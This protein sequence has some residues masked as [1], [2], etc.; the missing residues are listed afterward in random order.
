MR[1]LIYNQLK[2]C[3]LFHCLDDIELRDFISNS[4]YRFEEFKK[5]NTIISEQAS[6]EGL[7]IVLDGEIEVQKVYVT[8]NVIKVKDLC[9]GDILGLINVF[10]DTDKNLCTIIA[11][12]D[13]KVFFIAK[14]SVLDFSLSHRTFLVTLIRLISNQAVFLSHKLKLISFDTI[15]KKL[16]HYILELYEQ[17]KTLQLTVHATHKDIADLFGVSRPALSNELLHMKKEGLI[18]YGKGYMHIV[19]LKELSSQVY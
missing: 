17:Q 10:S 9:Q 15:R 11:K 2:I 13:C 3:P 5:G 7:G 1:D 14:E 19:D 4:K 8:G 12:S 18:D 6:A 16:A